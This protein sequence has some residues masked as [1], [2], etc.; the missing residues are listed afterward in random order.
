MGGKP[1]P[2]TAEEATVER[3]RQEFRSTRSDRA[4]DLA[5]IPKAREEFMAGFEERQAGRGRRPAAAKRRRA[6]RRR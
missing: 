2:D 1:I 4:R 5:A 3:L 6:K